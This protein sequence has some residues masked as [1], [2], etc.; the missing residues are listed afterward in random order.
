MEKR[1]APY[2]KWFGTAFRKLEAANTLQS[3]LQQVL[4]ASGWK[5]RQQHLSQAYE[6]V[7]NL[8]NQLNITSPLPNTVA[9]FHDRPFLVISMGAFSKAI[10]ATISDPVVKEIAKKRLIGGVDL[11]SDSTDILADAVWRPALR[12]LYTVI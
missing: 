8:H 7:V 3:I 1:Y 5:E 9:Q 11:L 12:E 6:Y 10:S 4:S 2:P